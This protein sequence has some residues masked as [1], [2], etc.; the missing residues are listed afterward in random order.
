M[1]PLKKKANQYNLYSL[2][3]KAL[4]GSAFSLAEMG[5]PT[6]AYHIHTISHTHSLTH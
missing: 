2:P 5:Q 6:L 1:V 3:T 4:K